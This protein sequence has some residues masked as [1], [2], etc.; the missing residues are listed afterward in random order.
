MFRRSLRR[1][2]ALF[3]MALLLLATSGCQLFSSGQGLPSQWEPD[4]KSSSP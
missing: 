2:R 4:V 3:G 1:R